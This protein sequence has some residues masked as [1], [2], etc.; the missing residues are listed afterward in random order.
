MKP[1][2]EQALGADWERL[3]PTVRRHY[4]LKPGEQLLLHGEMSEVYHSLWVKPFILIGR[5]FG[6]L[7]PYRGN[8]VPVEVHNLC[9]PGSN[10]LHFRRTFFFPNRRPYP[11]FSRMEPLQ[12]NEIVEFVRLGLGIRMKLSVRDGVLC[13]TTNGY[14][15]RPRLW[16]RVPLRLTLPDWLFFGSGTITERGLSDDE[17]ALD[18]T[19]RH[20]LFG[21]SFRYAG[22]FKLAGCPS[23]KSTDT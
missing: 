5:L 19:L 4:N 21:R 14:L 1:L 8:N 6:A 9:R 20:P 17:V 11:F 18:F 23:A 22:R 2:F 12:E 7:V 16:R 13:Y 10:A 3:H 15:W